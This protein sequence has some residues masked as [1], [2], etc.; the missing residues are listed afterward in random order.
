MLMSPMGI[1]R[2]KTLLEKVRTRSNDAEETPLFADIAT[3]HSTET[4]PLQNQKLQVKLA[5][6][7]GALVIRHVCC[8]PNGGRFS[9]PMSAKGQRKTWAAQ[10]I[11]CDRCRITALEHRSNARCA[12]AAAASARIANT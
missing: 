4:P 7:N 11:P 10:P 5:S 12:M 2:V 8:V 9:T 1:G 3:I 6:V